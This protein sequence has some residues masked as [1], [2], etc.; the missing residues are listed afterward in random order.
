MDKQEFFVKDVA[1]WEVENT[2]GKS[3]LVPVKVI[4]KENLF[5]NWRYTIIPVGGQGQ[6]ITQNLVKVK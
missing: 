1:L 3:V 5:G 6:T 2:S 4:K